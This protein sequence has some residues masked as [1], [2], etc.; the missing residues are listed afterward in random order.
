MASSDLN[1]EFKRVFLMIVIFTV[2]FLV[3]SYF[4][5][6]ILGLASFF[7]TQEGVAVSVRPSPRL[8]IVLFFLP[9]E[10]PI[11]PNVGPL[12][13]FLWIVYAACF[14]AAWRFRESLH[15][16]IKKALSRPAKSL[17][18]NSLFAMPI[19]ASMTMSAVIAL[20]SIQESGGIPTGEV[21]LPED[22]FETLF[23]LSYSPVFEEIGFRVLPIGTLLSASLLLIGRA[24]ANGS[25]WMTRLKLVVLALLY[26]ERAKKLVGA[27]TV[28]EFGVRGGISLGEWMMVILT[29]IVF[30][31]AHFG[32]GWQAGRISSAALQG[33]VFALTYLI[34]GVQAPILLHWFFNYYFTAF[35]L[36]SELYPNIS[37]IY[38]T[39]WTI[40][41]F[42][43]ILGWLTAAVLAAKKAA[44]VPVRR[45][46]PPEVESLTEPRDINLSGEKMCQ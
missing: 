24:K 42:L 46:R 15:S 27:K 2:L 6:M 34:Y 13:L 33:L 36:G 16:V 30:G 5:S 31:L 39:A 18:R 26:P 37:A 41:I 29:A 1:G 4:F 21:T 3:S 11:R 19:I 10:I 44:K 28:G 17:F 8:Q 9:I 23:L 35:N 45:T 38:L 22:P 14:A 32:G 7:F 40:T 25:S 20:H 12:F 43:G